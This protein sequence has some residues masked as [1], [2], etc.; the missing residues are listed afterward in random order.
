MGSRRK[1]RLPDSV[2]CAKC[3]RELDRENYS[4]LP[5]AGTPRE[6]IVRVESP[7]GQYYGVQCAG[8]GIYTVCVPKAWK[9]EA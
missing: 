8:C 4:A 2:R 1:D 5:D 7:T 6:L 9:R 3:G